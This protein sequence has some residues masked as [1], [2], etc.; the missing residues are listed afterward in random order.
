MTAPPRTTRRKNET[1]KPQSLKKKY[2][3]EKITQIK[4]RVD[5]PEVDNPDSNHLICQ[6]DLRLG[7]AHLELAN[8]NLG[9]AQST[10]EADEGRLYLDMDSP[11]LNP[12]QRGEILQKA[13]AAFHSARLMD[14]TDPDPL[15]GLSLAS[16]RM[17]RLTE[18]PHQKAYFL[19]ESIATGGTAQEKISAPEEER[20][21]KASVFTQNIRLGLNKHLA[22]MVLRYGKFLSYRADKELYLLQDRLQNR[23]TWAFEHPAQLRFLFEAKRYNVSEKAD[24]LYR[25][26]LLSR[27]KYKEAD[28]QASGAGMNCLECK[29][30][31]LDCGIQLGRFSHELDKP[32]EAREKLEDTI[33]QLLKIKKTER[34]RNPHHEESIACLLGDAYIRLSR[35]KEDNPEAAARS[36]IESLKHLQTAKEMYHKNTSPSDIRDPGIALTRQLDFQAKAF[37]FLG[38][39]LTKIDIIGIGFRKKLRRLFNQDKISKPPGSTDSLNAQRERENIQYAKEAFCA[40][41]EATR[42]AHDTHGDDARSR[43]HLGLAHMWLAKS[44]YM[45]FIARKQNLESRTMAALFSKSPHSRLRAISRIDQQSIEENLNPSEKDKSLDTML[46]QEITKIALSNTFS[47]RSI[48]KNITYF[49]METP[50]FWKNP[51]PDREATEKLGRELYAY[52][53]SIRDEIEKG[54]AQSIM[55]L[56]PNPI[57]TYIL[58]LVKQTFRIKGSRAAGRA[59]ETLIKTALEPKGATPDEAYWQIRK[60]IDKEMPT[61]IHHLLQQEIIADIGKAI[62][63][64]DRSVATDHE[65]LK[66]AYEKMMIN[67][68][69]KL[70]EIEFPIIDG[71]EPGS[72]LTIKG[73]ANLR[74]E[75][76]ITEF[77]DRRSKS[78][79][80]SVFYHLG[81]GKGRWVKRKYGFLPLFEKEMSPIEA[82][83]VARLYPNIMIDYEPDS[84][85]PGRGMALLHDGGKD[86]Q[87]QICTLIG[88]IKTLNKFLR[89]G[90]GDPTTIRQEM[91]KKTARR[92]SMYLASAKDIPRTGRAILEAIES[93]GA[94]EQ[95]FQADH[96][97]ATY[98]REA[99]R[100]TRLPDRIDKDGK[101]R[102]FRVKDQ[103]P[104]DRPE[105]PIFTLDDRLLHVRPFQTPDDY[106]RRMQDSL[107]RYARIEFPRYPRTGLLRFLI[108]YTKHIAIP[109]ARRQRSIYFDAK[110]PNKLAYGFCDLNSLKWTHMEENWASYLCTEGAELPGIKIRP[111]F[112]PHEMKR[113][114]AAL[115][116]ETCHEFPHYRAPLDDVLANWHAIEAGKA[117]TLLGHEYKQQIEEIN[118][119]LKPEQKS[120]WMR[121]SDRAAKYY[122]NLIV[123]SL[124]QAT[125]NELIDER[126]RKSIGRFLGFLKGMVVEPG[127]LNR[128]AATSDMT[129]EEEI[130]KAA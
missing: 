83:L 95:G 22:E 23:E 70:R 7:K 63:Y 121:K 69:F 123:H 68:H 28:C 66:P 94:S 25:T 33:K 119:R 77:K 65:Y 96:S 20:A 109:L 54:S 128:Q 51:K 127:Y 126:G 56:N 44:S 115:H 92:I 29:I 46:F 50:G 3:P 112:Q 62:E 61:N 6:I 31:M 91:A 99:I 97:A 79:N 118:L 122:K 64:F 2:F 120:Y 11:A 87:R 41:L 10:K 49:I 76:L 14:P 8:A 73:A 71:E 85:N 26:F 90:V 113:L 38:E 130:K 16:A 108:N 114:I 75:A 129:D 5:P 102:P 98:V 78:G 30:R 101:T 116:R 111:N 4:C 60:V 52:A 55:N 74:P 104:I 35:L 12:E 110:A 105:R 13:R 40:S 37:Q 67:S 84:E 1:P 34:R 117:L 93:G 124:E 17:A 27:E 39:A 82:R 47:P 24:L 125:R 81:K 32:R 57:W 53:S 43:Y 42:I 48:A 15:I 45:E 9:P 88:E 100:T 18:D 36:I 106:V 72:K 103:R 86:M 107:M 19:L 21:E 59:I 80:E 58:A 89:D